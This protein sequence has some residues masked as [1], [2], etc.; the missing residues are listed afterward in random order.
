MI[1]TDHDILSRC[2]YTHVLSLGGYVE[3]KLKFN[4]ATS[5]TVQE[6]GGWTTMHLACRY[7]H[8]T[9]VHDLMTQ[10]GMDPN[11]TSN[12]SN[13][14][15]AVGTSK[16]RAC[17]QTCVGVIAERIAFHGVGSAGRAHRSCS[18]AGRQIPS[19]P[20]V[21]NTGKVPII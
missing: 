9:L 11:E 4:L 6:L 8:H 3:I 20:Q 7:G 12:V 2:I 5:F 15:P 18:G 16:L 17:V 1:C 13:C 19:E 14:T 21:Y 10:Y